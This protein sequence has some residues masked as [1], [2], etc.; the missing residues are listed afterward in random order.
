MNRYQNQKMTNKVKTRPWNASGYLNSPQDI[1]AY[2]EAAFE[3]G[4]PQLIV[5]ALGDVARSKGMTAIAAQT[6]VGRESLYKALSL[7]GNPAF[8][9]VSRVLETLGMRLQTS[10]ISLENAQTDTALEP[11]TTGF[12]RPSGGFFVYSGES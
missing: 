2:L 7:G 11:W 1:V 8:A 3:D 9:T 5:A 4:D 12:L 6:G 10:E